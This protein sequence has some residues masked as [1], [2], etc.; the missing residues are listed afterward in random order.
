M[1]EAEASMAR[2]LPDGLATP[3]QRL[4]TV[5]DDGGQAVGRLWVHLQEHRGFIYDIEMRE[6]VRGQGLG[7]QTLR[8][9]AAHTSEVGLR[10]LALNVFGSNEPARRLYAREG[11][12]ETEV[13]WSARTD[14]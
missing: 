9:A 11:Y 12:T 4:W 1:A 5:C 2:L 8:A 3:G 13:I 6:S 10:L 7:T 14:A